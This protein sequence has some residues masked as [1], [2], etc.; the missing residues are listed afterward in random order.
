MTS[1]PKLTLADLGSMTLTADRPTSRPAAVP[2]TPAVLARRK[3]IT[4]APINPAAALIVFATV[5][6]FNEEKGFGFANAII[7]D[8]AQSVYFNVKKAVKVTGTDTEPVLTGIRHNEIYVTGKGRYPTEI[9]M[10]VGRPENPG[11]KPFAISWGIRP[12]PDWR[13]DVLKFEDGL[14]RF[15]GGELAIRAHYGSKPIARRTGRI[16][17]IEMTLTELTVVID[18]V[19]VTEPGAIT[20]TKRGLTALSFKLEDAHRDP[21]LLRSADHWR[22]MALIVPTPG[23]TQSKYVHFRM[24]A[25]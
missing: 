23:G 6:H 3:T 16:V 14:K 21:K 5:T 10:R 1:R 15:I 13:A 18:D 20:G 4:P 11:M 24:P 8:V 25:A 22:L 19:I 12:R 17:D 9:V 2:A 7:D